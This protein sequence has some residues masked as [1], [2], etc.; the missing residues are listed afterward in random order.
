MKPQRFLSL[1]GILIPALAVAQ[2]HANVKL[3]DS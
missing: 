3:V 1:F 2:E